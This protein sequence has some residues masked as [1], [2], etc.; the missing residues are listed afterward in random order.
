MTVSSEKRIAR[1]VDSLQ[2]IYSVVIALAIGQAIQTLLIDRT[3][4]TLAVPGVVLGRTPAFLALLAI[5]V[6]F[7]HG[8]NRH[9]DVAYIERA[10]EQRAEAALL[11]DFVVFFSSP[12]SCSPSPTQLG[13][14]W[15]PS[16]FL[17]LS[18]RLMCSGRWCLTGFTTAR[19]SRAFSAG[20]PSTPR[21]SSWDSSW[22]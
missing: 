3:T 12:V 1:S 18:W 20:P 5:L 6:P 16:P 21:R 17:G 8:M 7:Y 11:F 14:G 9:L 4:G 10:D 22:V 15:R 13:P 2:K 19:T